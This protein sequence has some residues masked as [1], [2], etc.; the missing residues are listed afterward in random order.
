LVYEATIYDEKVFTA[1]WKIRLPLYRRIEDNIQLLDFRCIEFAEE[2][3]YG[4]ITR[5]SMGDGN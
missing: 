3:M 1:P 2:M 5:K 4:P